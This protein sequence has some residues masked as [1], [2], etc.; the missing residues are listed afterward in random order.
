MNSNTTPEEASY[1]WGRYFEKFAGRDGTGRG[2]LNREDKEHIKRSNT[3]RQLF[4]KYGQS[5][6]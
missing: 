2:Y 5:S 1:A 6:S 4:T 3:S